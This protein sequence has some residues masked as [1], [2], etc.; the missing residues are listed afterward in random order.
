MQFERPLVAQ[1]RHVASSDLKIARCVAPSARAGFVRPVRIRPHTVIRR[2]PDAGSPLQNVLLRVLSAEFFA[3]FF[4]NFIHGPAAV[5]RTRRLGLPR[6]ESQ[7]GWFRE[8]WLRH[9]RIRCPAAPCN[10]DRAPACSGSRIGPHPCRYCLGS[11]SGRRCRRWTGR[12]GE[13][14]RGDDRRLAVEDRSPKDC[15]CARVLREWSLLMMER[16]DGEA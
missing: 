6:V 5:L 12:D 13:A 11:L 9:G 10:G 16:H 2:R 1:S 15:A 8:L 14:C 3:A 4:R 7:G